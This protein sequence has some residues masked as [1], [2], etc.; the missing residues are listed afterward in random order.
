MVVR[1]RVTALAPKCWTS[2]STPSIL[3]MNTSLECYFLF[4]GYVQLTWHWI[5]RVRPRRLLVQFICIFEL[6]AL[7]M[8]PTEL[9]RV[10]CFPMHVSTDPDRKYSSLSEAAAFAD[11]TTTWPLNLRRRS[12]SARVVPSTRGTPLASSMF[13]SKRTIAAGGGGKK[14]WSM[15]MATSAS[16]SGQQTTEVLRLASRALKRIRPRPLQMTREINDDKKHY[17]KIYKI[18]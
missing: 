11:R 10:S 3:F 8:S 12:S 4:Q 9:W 18:E 1:S 6:K 7:P 17:F 13:W 16:F 2:E 15:N 14:I 5:N